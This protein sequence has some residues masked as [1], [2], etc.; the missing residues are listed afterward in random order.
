[1]TTRELGHQIMRQMHVIEEV[2]EDTYIRHL[3]IFVSFMQFLIIMVMDVS[4]YCEITVVLLKL[5]S[6]KIRKIM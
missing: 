1:M 2:H 4:L 6:E 5:F 3:A